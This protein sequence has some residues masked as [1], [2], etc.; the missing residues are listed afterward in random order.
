MLRTIRLII[1]G[2]ILLLGG[3][4]TYAWVSRAPGQSVGE[5]FIALLGGASGGGD[6]GPVSA[7][8]VQ[9]PTGLALGGSFSLVNQEGKPVTERDF[10]GGWMLIYFG[11]TFCPD[12][13]PTELGTLAA[14]IDQLGPAGAKVVPVFITVDPQRDT[15]AHLADYVS[16][17]HP[18]MQGLTGTPE[19]VA[20]AARRYRVYYAKAQRPEMTDYLMDHSS[21][22]YLVGPDA[23]VRSLFRPEQSPETIAAT[24]AAQIGRPTG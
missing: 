8:G 11:Y 13:C 16:R 18:R 9:L 4:W 12:V 7:G 6:A 1:L 3:A 22:I 19:Q 20:E 24:I 2:L 21:F 23:K 5:A 17:F 10:G 14:A 15:P